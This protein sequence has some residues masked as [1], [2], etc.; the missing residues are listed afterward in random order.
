M[1]KPKQDALAISEFRE[2]ASFEPCE[3][4]YIKQSLDIAQN[5][6]GYSRDWA[7][8]A[9]EL[10]QIKAQ[11]A[12]YR[13]LPELK[14]CIPQVGDLIRLESFIGRLIKISTFDLNREKLLCFSS[15]RFLYERLL[16]ASVREWLPSSFCAAAAMPSIRPE[17]RKKLLHSISENAATA[18]G[19]SQTE[20]VFFPEWVDK[21]EYLSD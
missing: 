1:K 21:V 13:E 17:Q 12:L 20:P 8:D 10:S 5:L 2:F 4:R 14:N 11:I 7:R 6:G 15:Y 3:Q 18:P 19:W 9:T 16:G